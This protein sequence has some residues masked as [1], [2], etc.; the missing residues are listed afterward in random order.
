MK[1]MTEDNVRLEYTDRGQ[2]VPILLL[3]G[4]GSYKE[5][6]HPTER[7]LLNMAFE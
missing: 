2:G 5:L 4:L 3:A 6:W 7:F 1:L